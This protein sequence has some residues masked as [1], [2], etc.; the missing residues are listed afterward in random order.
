[1]RLACRGRRL[2]VVGIVGRRASLLWVHSEKVPMEADV[3]CACS[4]SPVEVEA[5]ARAPQ[6]DRTLAIRTLTRV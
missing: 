6:A 3:K 2:G 5:A 1:M 4:R